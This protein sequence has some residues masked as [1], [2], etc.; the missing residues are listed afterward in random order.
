MTLPLS[1]QGFIIGLL[2]FSAVSEDCDGPSAP[3]C[4]RRNNKESKYLCEWSSPYRDRI[5]YIHFWKDNDSFPCGMRYKEERPNWAKIRD[6]CVLYTTEVAIWVQVS[7]CTSPMTWVTLQDTI[8]YENPQNIMVSWFLGNLTLQWKAPEQNNAAVEI[9]HRANPSQTWNKINKTTAAPKDNKYALTLINLG[10]TSAKQL[11]IRHK[12]TKAKNP[13]WSNWA[14][15]LTDSIEFIRISKKRMNVT[16]RKMVVQRRQLTL[17]WKPLVNVDGEDVIYRVETQSFKNCSCHK[18]QWNTSKSCYKIFGSFSAVNL[19]VTALNTASS[20]PPALFHVPPENP[21]NLKVC[22][23]TALTAKTKNVCSQW[24]ELQDGV[25]KEDTVIVLPFDKKPL[26]KSEDKQR[27]QNELKEFLPYLYFEHGCYD[28]IQHTMKMCVY[29]KKE[30]APE[31]PPLS[32]AT[33]TEN[34]NFL[35]WKP[36]PTK[37]Q[38]GFITHYSLC[39]Q[40]SSEELPDCKNISSSLRNYTLKDLSPGTKYD[41]SLSGFTIEGE[42]PKARVTIN[43]PPEKPYNVGLSFMLLVIFFMLSTSCT[44]IFTRIKNKVFPPVPTPV[45]PG[46]PTVPAEVQDLLERKEEVDKVILVQHHPECYPLKD[47]E[48]SCTLD[49]IRVTGSSHLEGEEDEEENRSSQIES[50]NNEQTPKDPAEEELTDPDQIQNEIALLV[51]RNGLV[52]DVNVDSV[53]AESSM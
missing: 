20:S 10:K 43:T 4:F 34:L 24:Y 1:L 48:R 8:K 28:K 6:E 9:W 26:N 17:R 37:E 33:S 27:I 13:L 29:Y 7:N 5:H 25:V 47:T 11:Q 50:E 53:N 14:K 51:Y 35:S 19:S 38:R 44:F 31:S 32:F 49:G 41:I 30:G 3:E 36:I 40:T 52:F 12:S 45:I 22:N 39:I 23:E 18:Q 16:T 2:L 21:P 15:V 46:F 42:G